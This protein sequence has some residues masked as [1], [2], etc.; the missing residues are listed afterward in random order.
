MLN[1]HEEVGSLSAAEAQGTFLQDLLTRL[2]PD[3]V[4]RRQVLAASLMVSVD[5]AHAV[6]PNFAARHDPEHLPL[7][8]GGPVI[9]MNAAG[10]YATS[11]PT[12]ALFRTFC[13]QAGVPCQQFVMR[14]DLACGSTIGPLTAAGL[15]VA[16]VDVGIPQLAMH[17]IRET[18]GSRDGWSLLR[19][20]AAFLAT[21]D[22]GI[23]CP[24]A[25][26]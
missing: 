7:L 20:L 6:H 15:G 19:A 4:L 5:N 8:N 3:P 12:A 25:R 14:N 1:D 13:R 26:P 22:E 23:R 11:G 18:A 2:Y 17:S 16:A 9:K 24:A 21:P 10:R